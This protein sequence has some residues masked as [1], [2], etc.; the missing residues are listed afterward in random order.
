MH[1][2]WTATSTA[3]CRLWRAGHLVI[4]RVT[5]DDCPLCLGRCG[6][7][8]K[9]WGF[10]RS[11]SVKSSNHAGISGRSAEAAAYQPWFQGYGGHIAAIVPLPQDI[12][13][14]CSQES[15]YKNQASI[16]HVTWMLLMLAAISTGFKKNHC[17]YAPSNRGLAASLTCLASVFA[18]VW[19][20]PIRA[21]TCWSR[22][23]RMRMNRTIDPSPR[24]KL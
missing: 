8:C 11:T 24:I 6:S 5:S 21:G 4:G 19:L 15:W 13:R 9:H 2:G 16:T 23:R 22:P 14:R 10:R 3:E 7:R 20:I 17:Q 1:C 12:W 18:L